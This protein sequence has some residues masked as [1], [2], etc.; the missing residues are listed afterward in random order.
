MIG[1]S[2]SA[3]MEARVAQR[4]KDRGESDGRKFEATIQAPKSKA[5]RISP[6]RTPDPALHNNIDARVDTSDYGLM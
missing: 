5:S 2:D 3:A 1:M 4:G 6:S